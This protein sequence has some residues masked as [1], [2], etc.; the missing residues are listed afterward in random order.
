MQPAQYRLRLN[1]RREDA[2]FT[3]VELMMVMVVMALLAGIT[4]SVSKYAAWR[5]SQAQHE[6]FIEKIKAA[7]DEYRAQNGEYPIVGD[8]KHYARLFRTECF[9]TGNSPW[10]NV[11]LTFSNAVENMSG[12]YY[13]DYSLTY[14]LMYGPISKGREPI[15]VFPNK[16]ICSLAYRFTGSGDIIATPRPDGTVQY[17]YMT[18]PVTR[19]VAIDPMSQFQWRYVCSNGVEYHFETNAF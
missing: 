11:D 10:T 5:A 15:M 4:I 2:S 9:T 7:L 18:H 6:A 16:T 14:P 17:S 12:I 8:P 3:L 19:R 13:V 1:K